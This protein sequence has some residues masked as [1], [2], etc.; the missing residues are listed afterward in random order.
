[1]TVSVLRWAAALAGAAA[2]LL[3]SGCPGGGSSCGPTSGTVVEVVD[4]DT[5]YLSTGE[6]IRYLMVDAPEITKGHNDCYGQEAAAFNKDM[7]LDQTVTL[8]YDKECTDKYGRLLAYVSFE[9]REV[10]SLLVER[11]F[12]CVLH[13]PPNGED[14][15]DEFKTL[16]ADAKSA[17]RG[18]WGSCNPLPPACK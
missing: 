3:L 11:G 15:V 10:N 14:R 4:G 6:K 9:G 1:M 16:Q 13:I 8:T 2:A 18:A 17:K 7:V 5:V 12:A